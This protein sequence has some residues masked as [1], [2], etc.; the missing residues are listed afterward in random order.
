M[1]KKIEGNKAMDWILEQLKVHELA[2]DEFTIAMVHEQMS[3]NGAQSPGKDA[4]K[5][6]FLRM[7]QT[8]VMTSRKMLINGRWVSVFRPAKTET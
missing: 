6:K 5:N 7:E 4:L 8:G 1:A 2:A 3:K